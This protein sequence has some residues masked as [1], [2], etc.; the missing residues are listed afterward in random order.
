[1]VLSFEIYYTN[2]IRKSKGFKIL[3]TFVLFSF[4][5]VFTIDHKILKYITVLKSLPQKDFN[6][7]NFNL[8]KG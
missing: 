6:S 8:L 7:K 1:M 5:T 4:L 3:K 2:A